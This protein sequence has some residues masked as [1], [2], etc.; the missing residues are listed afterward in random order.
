MTKRRPEGSL[1]EAT[2]ELVE[3]AGGQYKAAD[4]A[5]L[6]QTMMV[7]YTDPDGRNAETTMPVAVVRT[8]EAHTQDPVLT[9]F[10]AAELGYI[11]LKIPTAAGSGQLGAECAAMFAE[12]ADCAAEMCRALKD[13]R[14]SHAEAGRVINA[15]DDVVEKAAAIRAVLVPIRD[16]KGA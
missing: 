3:A 9:R 1:K 15:L 12:T 13:N 14:I 7:R 4:L 16:G 5:G 8:L 6:S 10:L 2:H 11:L